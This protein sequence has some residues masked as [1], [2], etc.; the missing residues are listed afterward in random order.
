MR[1]PLFLLSISTVVLLLGIFGIMSIDPAPVYSQ[2]IQDEMPDLNGINIYFSETNAEASQFDRSVKGVSRFAGLLRL[3]GANLFT[4]EWRKGIPEDADLIIIPSPSTDLSADLVAR[5]WAYLQRG[6][7]VLVIADPIDNRGA[8]SRAL[9]TTG[10]FQLTWNDLGFQARQDVIVY[11]GDYRQNNVEELD[12][13]GNI[14]FEFSG[15]LPELITRFQTSRISDSHP[16]TRE[17]DPILA[18]NV[19]GTRLSR[20]NMNTFFFDGVRSIEID[21]SLDDSTVTPLIF[22][23]NPDIYG[24]TDFTRYLTNGY[25]E[26]NIG[27]DS[28]RGDLVLAASYEDLSVNSRMILVSDGDFVANGGGFVTSPSYSGS[29]VYPMNVQFMLRS[30]AWLLDREPV[31]VD[32]PTPA[33]TTTATTTPTSMPT[34]TVTP[35]PTGTIESDT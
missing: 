5:L 29:F 34:A 27:T 22:T 30:V 20:S 8:V 2:D 26:Y 28:Q 6:G 18:S 25:V 19:S 24:E 3:S 33:A 21:A 10:L 1:K 12:R 7:K 4:L 17:L 14:T 13:E 15:E 9:T 31:I 35:T 16:I 23:D 11:E 32:L